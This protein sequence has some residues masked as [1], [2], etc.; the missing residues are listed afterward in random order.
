MRLGMMQPYF[1]PY[2]GYFALIDATDEWVVFDTP[3]YIRRGWVNRNRVL[4]S[5]KDGWKYVRIP[6]EKASQLTPISHMKA[7]TAC[8]L[9]VDVIDCLD[10]YRC[11]RAPFYD[12]TR[13]LLV[14]CLSDAPDD[15]TECLVRCLTKTCEHLQ[16]PFGPRLYSSLDMTPPANPQPGD[17]ALNT[18]TSLGASEYLNPPGG[19]Q[20]FDPN[21]FREAS[22]HLTFLTHQ[23]TPYRQRA[24][25][26]AGLS[27]IDVLMW[28]GRVR[29]RELITDYQLEQ[30][31]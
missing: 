3:Q 6:V 24:E 31:A 8:R 7:A 18:A 28:N 23:L 16:I 11:W 5:G 9:S 17:W 29:T 20:L 1:F 13:Q 22:I 10:E 26:V 19:R 12:E 27:I 15:L 14:E 25:F 4:S 21:A 2:L 30:V